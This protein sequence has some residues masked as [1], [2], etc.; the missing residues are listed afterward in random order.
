M[1]SW[2][3]TFP[4]QMPWPRREH[5]RAVFPLSP[6]TPAI[7]FLP[8]LQYLGLSSFLYAFLLLLLLLFALV[9]LVLFL[10]FSLLFYL[11]HCCNFFGFFFS[12]FFFRNRGVGDY[13]F[14]KSTKH[15][16]RLGSI[17]QG[18]ARKCCDYSTGFCGWE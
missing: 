4:T 6:A 14:P 11:R 8:H 16:L 1:R 18:D 10:P 12:L 17:G 2:C 13:E 5:P 9:F 15:R 7:L 3:R